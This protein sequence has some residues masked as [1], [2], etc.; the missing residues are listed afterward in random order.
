MIALHRC[1]WS[2]RRRRL[3]R[4]IWV[5]ETCWRRV[6]WVSWDREARG[7]L[8][9]VVAPSSH[10]CDVTYGHIGSNGGKRDT[11]APHSQRRSM[12]HSHRRLPSSDMH[13]IIAGLDH[14][15]L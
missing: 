10:D 3:L 2:W 9:I 8:C 5:G 13:A 11:A 7:C 4:R 1:Q 15:E 12:T 6:R 14:P